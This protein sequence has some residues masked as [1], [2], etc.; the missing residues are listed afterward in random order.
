M[1]LPITIH[2]LA[3]KTREGEKIVMVTAYDAP[4]AR[5]AEAG[6]ADVLL[7]GDSLGMVVLG[8]ADTLN[9]TLEDIL[10]HTRAVARVRELALIVADLPF[11][12][13]QVSVEQAITS[14]GRLLQ[15][16]HAHA[17]KLEGGSPVLHSVERMV[18]SGIPVM[19]HLGLTPQSIHQLGG[20]KVQGK[21]P[22]AA[23]RM[24]ADAHALES[25]G[26]FSLVLECVPSDLAAL[27]A[28]ELTIPVI[29]IG[30]G[31]EVDGQ[32]LVFHDIL[33]YGTAYA[34]KFVRAY[35]NLNELIPQAIAQF[36]ADVREGRFPTSDEAYAPSPEVLDALRAIAHRIG[37]ED[38]E[39]LAGGYGGAS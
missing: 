27:I 15:E 22:D 1:A 33:R 2:T 24:V 5:L 26:A 31:A 34:P 9:V 29:G 12:S 25:A 13:Y 38:D 7:V 30:A 17:V 39:E 36:A 35:A 18:A 37:A 3:R 20:Y 28:R 11:M 19:A 8:Y 4:S 21:T 23:A 10:H 6:G 32:V 16:G 14:A